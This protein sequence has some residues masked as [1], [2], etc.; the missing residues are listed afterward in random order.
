VERASRAC[1]TR[2]Y[3]ERLL[4]A[5]L[6]GRRQGID[7]LDDFTGNLDRRR[8]RKGPAYW[9]RCSPRRGPMDR[10]LADV[11]YGLG[12]AQLHLCRPRPGRASRIGERLWLAHPVRP[13]RQERHRDAVEQQPP[14]R[15]GSSSSSSTCSTA[16]RRPIGSGTRRAERRYAGAGYASGQEACLGLPMRTEVSPNHAAIRSSSTARRSGASAGAPGS[17]SCGRP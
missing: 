3:A 15:P 2:P 4:K 13:C 10:A 17:R 12:L 7:E 6:R 8:N 11:A 1:F 5:G 14:P 16:C 9:I